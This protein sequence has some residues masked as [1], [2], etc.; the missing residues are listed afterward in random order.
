MNTIM[1]LIEKY[2]RWLMSHFGKEVAKEILLEDFGPP[3]KDI[4][5]AAN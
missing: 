4:C 1:N 5:S 2:P 3:E